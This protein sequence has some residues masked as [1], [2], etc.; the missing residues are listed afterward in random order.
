MYS[1]QVVER[2]L[3]SR[4]FQDAG[5]VMIYRGIRGEVRL[6]ELECAKESEGKQ[7]LFPLCLPERQMAALAPNGEDSWQSGSYGIMEPVMERSEL[8]LPEDIDLIICP[9]TVFDESC[10]RMGMGGGYY[11]RYLPKCKNAVVAAAA[12]EVQK[13]EQVPMEPW[14]KAVDLVFTEKKTYFKK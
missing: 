11:D 10:N 6:D 13:A 7:F 2:I 4:V 9:C 3:A 8:I 1:Q 12:F 5:T 14:D